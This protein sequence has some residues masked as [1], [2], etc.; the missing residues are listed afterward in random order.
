MNDAKA[1]PISQT[2]SS[3][4][5]FTL[6]EIISILILIG[7]FSATVV[8]KIASTSIYEISTEL[9]TLKTH[10]RFAQSRAMSHNQPWGIS[11]TGSS[12][13][14]QKNGSTAPINLPNDTSATHTFANGVSIASGNRV[15]TFDDMGNHPGNSDIIVRFN[16]PSSPVPGCSQQS[17]AFSITITKK[18]GFIQ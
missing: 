2:I 3:S 5:G 7:I 1:Y 17:G 12:Y 11:I 15:V 8:P 10:L 14:L 9:E 4:N 16:G 18:T 6:I 13:T